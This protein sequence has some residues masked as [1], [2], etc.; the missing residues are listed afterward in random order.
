M[1][2]LSIDK[3]I[4]CKSVTLLDQFISDKSDP[5]FVAKTLGP[6]H[7]ALT[8]S[9]GRIPPEGTCFLIAKSTKHLR[10]KTK[11]IV[12]LALTSCHVAYNYARK[13]NHEHYAYFTIGTQDYKY[14]YK[15]LLDLHSILEDMQ[16]STTSGLPY[17][18][19]NDI[20]LLLIIESSGVEAELVDAEL[21]E[22][23][24]EEA[25]LEEIEICNEKE[26]NDIKN[27]II[28]GFP[29]C[30]KQKYM[31]ITSRKLTDYQNLSSQIIS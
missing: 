20:G 27:T 24:Q 3:Q 19:P 13:K 1:K 28:S 8:Q 16:L 25:E 22:V 6:E 31:K 11:K 21:V 7:R 29:K 30:S 18:V 5:N 2:L 10:L 9:I 15:P 14:A 4:C 17:C 26:R 23:E 12:G